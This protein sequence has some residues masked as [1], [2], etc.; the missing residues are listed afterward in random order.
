MKISSSEM[1]RINTTQHKFIDPKISS[2][3]HRLA[4]L[5]LSAG[6]LKRLQASTP[7]TTPAAAG[8]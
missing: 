6:L 5:S 2:G 7:P 8:L 4:P 1:E 3:T